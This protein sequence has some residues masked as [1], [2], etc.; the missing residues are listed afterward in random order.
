MDR[1][2]A[3]IARDRTMR[4]TTTANPQKKMDERL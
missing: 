1:V 4:K 3:D 2:I